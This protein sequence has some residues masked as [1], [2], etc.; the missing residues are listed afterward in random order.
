M[1]LVISEKMLSEKDFQECYASIEYF[2][3]EVVGFGITVVNI[4]HMKVKANGKL[5]NIL[6]EEFDDLESSNIQVV[7][8]S[9]I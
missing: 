3:N 8:N 5:D 6:A 7:Y 2:M 4:Q 9:V 1:D